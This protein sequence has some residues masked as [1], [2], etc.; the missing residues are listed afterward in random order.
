MRKFHESGNPN[1]ATWLVG[2][3]RTGGNPWLSRPPA[4]RGETA[5]QVEEAQKY[6]SSMSFLASFDLKPNLATPT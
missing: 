4:A 3:C 1:G 6:F 2:T 5:S